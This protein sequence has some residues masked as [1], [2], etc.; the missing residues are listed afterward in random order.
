MHSLQLDFGGGG[1]G[2][3]WGPGFSKQA[4]L[5]TKGKAYPEPQEPFAYAEL[6]SKPLT[7]L[8]SNSIPFSLQEGVSCSLYWFLIQDCGM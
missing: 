4:G 7:L 8:P 1:A 3:R 5:S 6:M 2:M